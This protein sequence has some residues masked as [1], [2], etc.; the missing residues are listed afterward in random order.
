MPDCST[1]G[2]AEKYEESGEYKSFFQKALYDFYMSIGAV[3]VLHWIEI[4]ESVRV[5]EDDPHCGQCT[6]PVKAG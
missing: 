1:E 2:Y 5:D 6:D 4:E 3:F